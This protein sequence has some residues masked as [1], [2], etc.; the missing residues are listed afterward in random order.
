MV[1][2]VHRKSRRQRSASIKGHSRKHFSRFRFGARIK[3]V[4][5][6]LSVETHFP[7]D[8][9][10]EICQRTKITRAPCR[11]HTGEAVPR[12]EKIGDL[13][14][15]DH[16]VLNEVCES[17]HNLRYAVVVQDLATQ[18]VQLY[19]CKTKNFFGDEKEFTKGSRAR[20]KSAKS[21][22]QTISLE[23]GISCEDLSWNPLYINA[24]SI[25]DKWHC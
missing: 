1:G 9:N 17:R 16:K 25:R 24:T 10:C 3:T 4:S 6:K 19:T 22:I 8:R 18:W 15:A 14:T 23:F 2:G 11:K 7:K 20:R 21:C 5:R 13:K 12:A